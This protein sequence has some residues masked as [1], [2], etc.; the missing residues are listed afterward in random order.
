MSEWR[1]RGGIGPMRWHLL[2]GIAACAASVGAPWLSATRSARVEDRCSELTTCLATSVQDAARHGEPDHDHVLAR[3]VAFAGALGVF[4]ADLEARPSSEAGWLLFANKHYLFRAAPIAP[5]PARRHAEDARP[6]YEVLAW[7]V[8]AQSAGHAM[9]YA[10]EDAPRSYTRNLARGYQGVGDR[11][12]APG[13]GRRRA[14]TE[15]DQTHSYRSIGDD[16]W[17]CY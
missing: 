11:M 7:P 10:A 2:A 13:H 5:D 3:T 6:A 4:A 1:K 8:D 17:I 15:F 9:F 14:A 16:R 12:A